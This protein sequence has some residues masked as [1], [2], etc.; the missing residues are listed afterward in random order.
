MDF[1]FVWWTEETAVNFKNLKK[2]A[3]AKKKKKKKMKLTDFA[4]YSSPS[5]GVWNASTFEITC[6]ELKFTLE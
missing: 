1:F 6:F 3:I 2:I 4:S 5:V